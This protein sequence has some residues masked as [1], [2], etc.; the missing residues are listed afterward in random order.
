M[1]NDVDSG[2][3]I[4]DVL[5]NNTVTWCNCDDD[6]ITKHSGYPIIVYDN[7]SKENEQKGGFLL[8]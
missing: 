8:S 2:H 5:K 7:L 4:C 6:T 3:Y 1:S